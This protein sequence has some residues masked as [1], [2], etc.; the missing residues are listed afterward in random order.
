[1]LEKLL[2]LVT[3]PPDPPLPPTQEVF[4]D[5]YIVL[6]NFCKHVCELVPI[7]VSNYLIG[8]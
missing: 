7:V 6:F 3:S 8:G 1:M 5:L 4:L 2:T